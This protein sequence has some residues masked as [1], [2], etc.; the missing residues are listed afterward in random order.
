MNNIGI[1]GCGKLGLYVANHLIGNDFQVRGTT[2]SQ[3][4]LHLFLQTKIEGYLYDLGSDLPTSFFKDLDVLIISIPISE[5]KLFKEF[6]PLLDLLN[7]NLSLETKLIFTSSIG[8]YES[9]QG[10]VNEINGLCKVNSNNFRLE[11]ELRER[12]DT[13]L[14]ILRLGGLISN[15]RHPVFS[16]AGR[17][18]ATNGKAPINLVHHSDVS[19]M[20]KKIIISKKFGKVYNCV[21]PSHPTKQSYYTDVAIIK[22]IEAPQFEV[23]DSLEKIVS[24]E[25][26]SFDLQFEY[27][28]TI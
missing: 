19:R 7:L 2:R 14:T 15:E 27:K 21:F 11:N 8:V 1:L 5:T 10:L 4:N 23:S 20:I 9:N 17:K 6:N 3:E 26:S 28:F 25:F 18:L 12:Y 22:E 13:R 24:S 16:L